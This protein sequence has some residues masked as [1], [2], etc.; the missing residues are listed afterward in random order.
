MTARFPLS[1]VVL[2]KDEASNIERCLRSVAWCDD[3]VVVDD[4]ST[5]RTAE[6]ATACGARVLRNRFQSFARQRNWALEHADLRHDWVLM[7]DA[8]EVVTDGLRDELSRTLPAAPDQVVA[9]RLC[10]KTM[11]LGRWLKHSDG[12]PVWIM[13]LVRRGQAAFQDSGHGEVPVPVVPGEVGT[14][15]EPFLHYPFSRGIGDWVDRHNRYASREA[16]LELAE[17]TRWRF[18]DVLSG[19]RAVRRRTLRRISR[20]LPGRPFLRF[21]Y[22]YLW[23]MGFLEGRAGLAFSLLMAWYEGLIVLKREEIERPD[24]PP[25]GER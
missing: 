17:Q 1:V 15:G 13:R 6:L 12:F 21:G 2:T 19:D 8:D 25:A 9:Y 5:D 3:V 22:Q 18:R 20:T 11:F 10:R 23:K 7:L 16:E 4:H 24:S 14:I